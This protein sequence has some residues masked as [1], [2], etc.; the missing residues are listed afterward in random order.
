MSVRRAR[1][2]LHGH[3]V[4]PVSGVTVRSLALSGQK[5]QKE[6]RNALLTP[7]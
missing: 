2:R 3:F 4:E 6:G 7:A 1:E 5:D